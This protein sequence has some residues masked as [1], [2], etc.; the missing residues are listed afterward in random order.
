M[1]EAD[2]KDEIGP[3]RPLFP[4]PPPTHVYL[5]ANQPTY[6]PNLH[7]YPPPPRSEAVESESYVVKN[8]CMPN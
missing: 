8:V 6:P 3:F 5:Q 2:S 4:H 1:D 7:I